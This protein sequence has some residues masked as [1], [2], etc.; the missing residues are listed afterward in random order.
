MTSIQVAKINTFV[1][2][3]L[4]M[5][6]S[7][8]DI[9]ER[10]NNA[11]NQENLKSLIRGNKW[12]R[13]KDKNRPKKGPT[14]YLLFCKEH[15]PTVKAEL[16]KKY[17][18]SSNISSEVVTELATRWKWFKMSS[19]SEDTAK[20]QK[21]EIQAAKENDRYRR[22]MEEYNKQPKQDK[23][24]QPK[25]N[26][27]P[28]RNKSAYLFFS[29]E[30]HSQVKAELGEEHTPKQLM[31]EKGKRWKALHDRTKFTTLAEADVERYQREKETYEQRHKPSE[32][33]TNFDESE[34]PESASVQVSGY[35]HFVHSQRAAVMK[36]YPT[37]DIQELAT[38]LSELWNNLDNAQQMRWRT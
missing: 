5:N 26:G 6:A 8:E 16:E 35:K 20:L 33:Q 25:K 22:E 2:T 24:K 31:M 32:N 17:N 10:W 21:Y 37:L 38:K 30:I 27:Y 13:T 12:K 23:P 34:P 4:K 1:Q 3:F 18:N 36:Q 9:L 11:E 28:K 29:Q 7:L 19:D 15:R 14:A